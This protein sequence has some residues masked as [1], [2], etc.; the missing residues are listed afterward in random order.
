[1][2]A[3]GEAR[4]DMAGSAAGSRVDPVLRQHPPRVAAPDFKNPGEFYA[5]SALARQGERQAKTLMKIAE[6]ALAKTKA[7]ARVAAR[8]YTRNASNDEM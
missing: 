1:M 6:T 8:L 5:I 7:L 4:N 2:Q 3:V